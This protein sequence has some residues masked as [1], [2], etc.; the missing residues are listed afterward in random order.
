MAFTDIYVTKWFFSGFKGLRTLQSADSR[1]LLCKNRFLSQKTLSAHKNIVY[2][3]NNRNLVRKKAWECRAGGEKFNMKFSR[4]GTV[5]FHQKTFH[6]FVAAKSIQ[7][8]TCF[9]K[10]RTGIFLLYPGGFQ[11]L[12]WGFIFLC[13]LWQRSEISCWFLGTCDDATSGNR[14]N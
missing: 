13:L 9:A 5:L 1:A 6:S 2:N 4:P 8:E 7:R 11:L 10:I 12:F 3:I 14:Q